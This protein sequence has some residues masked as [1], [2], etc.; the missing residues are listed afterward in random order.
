MTVSCRSCAGDS[1]R[2]TGGWLEFEPDTESLPLFARV[3]GCAPAVGEAGDEPQPLS[4]RL[5]FLLRGCCRI[6]PA[7]G[8]VTSTR[9]RSG[10]RMI[11]SPIEVSSGCCGW[12]TALVT[13]SDVSS[14]AVAESSSAITAWV[15]WRISE[16]AR[17]GAL[18]PPGRSRSTMSVN[19]RRLGDWE[20][21]PAPPF[22]PARSFDLRVAF[23]RR[24][25]AFSRRTLESSCALRASA[26]PNRDAGPPRR[27]HRGPRPAAPRPPINGACEHGCLACG[28]SLA[29]LT[30]RPFPRASVERV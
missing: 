6:E 22:A 21:I 16:R 14:V 15:A 8:V 23:S 19:P 17:P 9:T 20:V 13:S 26:T 3:A 11:R 12:V 10:V 24:S 30:A 28:N 7:P 27:A 2:V 25:A 4:A 18:G 5:G 1:A 29:A